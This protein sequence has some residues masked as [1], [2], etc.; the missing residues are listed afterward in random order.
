MISIRHIKYITHNRIGRIIAIPQYLRYFFPPKLFYENAKFAPSIQ[1]ANGSTT[2]EGEMDVALYSQKDARVAMRRLIARDFFARHRRGQCDAEYARETST[3]TSGLYLDGG[4]SMARGHRAPGRGLYLL[5][6]RAGERTR[7][8]VHNPENG[9]RR[10]YGV[11]A[12]HVGPDGGKKRE[13]VDAT[14]YSACSELLNFKLG[15]IRDSN[16]GIISGRNKRKK[17]MIR[18]W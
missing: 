3:L 17:K 18:I 7:R 10:N 5:H 13:R 4:F 12:R 14:K 15:K 16:F 11:F 6:N 2:A 9:P 8:P 1:R